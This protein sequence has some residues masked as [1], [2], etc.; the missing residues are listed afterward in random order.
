MNKDTSLPVNK[1][2]ELK[3][4]KSIQAFP[5]C[6]TINGQNYRTKNKRVKSLIFTTRTLLPRNCALMPLPC[7]LE[8]ST[9]YWRRAKHKQKLT[10]VRE[11][12]EASQRIA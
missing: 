6:A 5:T 10:I 8:E 4:R 3:L 12:K 9:V 1:I 11:D 7:K 2:N